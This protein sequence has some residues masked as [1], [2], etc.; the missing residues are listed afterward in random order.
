MYCTKCGTE[1]KES[2]VYCYKCGEK[3]V[4]SNENLSQNEVSNGSLPIDEVS[5]LVREKTEKCYATIHN[6]VKDRKIKRS[7]IAVVIGVLLAIIV[8]V[9][10]FRDNNINS[11]PEAV[12]DNFFKA[13]YKED[14]DL[15]IK[16]TE[17][18]SEI[19]K[20]G[21]DDL[22]VKLH[23]ANVEEKNKVLDNWYSKVNIVQVNDV[24]NDG[25][26]GNVVNDEKLVN[27]T[28]VGQSGKIAVRKI[29]R[30]Y[31]IQYNSNIE[32]ADGIANTLDL[33]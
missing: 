2:D 15:L 31:Y 9:P 19:S 5:K 4:N 10:I 12:T 25:G 7:T 29:G 26:N 11:S 27:V 32:G 20:F 16:C 33:K 22:R 30:K 1:L 21:E 3:T 14:P 6:E 28:I 24:A 23:A 8:V 17:P 13:V 18:N